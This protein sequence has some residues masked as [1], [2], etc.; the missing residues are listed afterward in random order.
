MLWRSLYS[1]HAK[2]R[3]VADWILNYV[4]GIFT[5]TIFFSPTGVLGST[6]LLAQISTRY[7][8]GDKVCSAEA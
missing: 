5:E 6:Q 3:K 4:T 7:F 8:P 1:Y 2:G